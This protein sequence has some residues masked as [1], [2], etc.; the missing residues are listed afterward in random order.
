MGIKLTKTRFDILAIG[1]IERSCWRFFDVS[2][3]EPRCVG[4][5]YRTKGEAMADLTRYAKDSWGLE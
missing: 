4:P 3:G 5:L 2:D 1:Q